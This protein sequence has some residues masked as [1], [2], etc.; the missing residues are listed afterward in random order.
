MRSA[1]H[2]SIINISGRDR[3]TEGSETTDVNKREEI[4]FIIRQAC[5]V[6]VSCRKRNKLNTSDLCIAALN[7]ARSVELK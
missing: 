2:L 5:G 4:K 1:T 3:R 6:V 7:Y